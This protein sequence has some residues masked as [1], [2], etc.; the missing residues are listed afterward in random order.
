MY[1]PALKLKL[2]PHCRVLG[3]QYGFHCCCYVGF[4]VATEFVVFEERQRQIGV[5]Q[6]NLFSQV[7]EIRAL[8]ESELNSRYPPRDRHGVPFRQK[9]ALRKRGNSRLDAKPA[10]NRETNIRNIAIAPGNRIQLVAPLGRN[11]SA[12]GLYYPDNPSQWPAV[13]KIIKQ[14]KPTLAGPFDLKQSG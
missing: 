10:K 2:N 3:W 12:I 7:G 14:K 8:I 11:E 9:W 13:E 4:L 1:K 5:R 6:Q